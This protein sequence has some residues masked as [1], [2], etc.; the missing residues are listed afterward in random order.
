MFL[1]KNKHPPIKVT[2]QFLR[3]YGNKEGTCIVRTDQGGELARSVLVR[4]ALQDAS[5]SIEITGSDNSSQNGA[6]ERPHRTLA[7]MVRAGL[8]TSNLP[9]KYWSDALLHASFIKNRLPHYKFQ[10][11]HTPYEKL[12]GIT[13][14]LS[15]LRVFGSRIVTRRPGQRTTKLTKHSY[16]GIFL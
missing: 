3:T 1:S 4:K 9:L 12:T 16:T 11:K 8:E 15:N 14:D 10:L 5:Y 2:K 6:A 13:P 7:N